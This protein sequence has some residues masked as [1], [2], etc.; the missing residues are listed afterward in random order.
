MTLGQS[1]AYLDAYS[2]NSDGFDVVSYS[3][4]PCR[5]LNYCKPSPGWSS[6]LADDIAAAGCLRLVLSGGNPQ[7]VKFALLGAAKTIYGGDLQLPEVDI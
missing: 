6:C 3:N 7:T 2:S 4:G 1:I 5:K